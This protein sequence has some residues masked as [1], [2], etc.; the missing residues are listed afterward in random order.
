[1]PLE[2]D[3]IKNAGKR[4]RRWEQLP[5]LKPGAVQSSSQSYNVNMITFSDEDTSIQDGE[6]KSWRVGKRQNVQERNSSQLPL[7]L[8][9]AFLRSW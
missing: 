3:L 6:G 4:R 7:I 8:G 5:H 1:M 9:S 2:I